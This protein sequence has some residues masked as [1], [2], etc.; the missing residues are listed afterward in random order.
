MIK[1]CRLL[2]VLGVFALAACV[3]VP[4]V[5]Q[6]NFFKAKQLNQLKVGM[7]PKQVR[8]LFGTPM[9]ADPFYP[10]RWDYVFYEKVEGSKRRMYHL[11]VYFKNHK[12]SRFSTSGPIKQNS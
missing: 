7:T 4:P 6:G 12:V 11:T 3:Y 1:Y 5:T 9:L 2:L 10:H 8:Y